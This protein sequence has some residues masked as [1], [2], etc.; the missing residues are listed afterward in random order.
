[1]FRAI[2]GPVVLAAAVLCTSQ[3]AFAAGEQNWLRGAAGD[4][5]NRPE[6]WNTPE[7]VMELV[8]KKQFDRTYRFITRLNPYYLRGDFNGDGRA[9]VAVL[10]ERLSDKKQG[11]AIFHFGEATIRVVGAGRPLNNGLDDFS[12]MD[13]WYVYPKMP[14]EQGVEEGPPPKLRGE[15][16]SVEQW[17]SGSAIVYWNGQQYVWYQQGD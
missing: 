6:L 8:R 13:I 4:P 1:M 3:P 7:W 10:I 17:E 9:D 12:W 15:A 5:K 11:I 14:V 2:A 16:L